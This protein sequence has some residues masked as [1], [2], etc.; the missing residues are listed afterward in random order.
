MNLLFSKITL[1][2]SYKRMAPPLAAV[3]LTNK[4]FLTYV[5]VYDDRP[6]VLSGLKPIINA[7][8]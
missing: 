2:E 3:L 6:G 1:P 7:P 5:F 8:P 4:Q